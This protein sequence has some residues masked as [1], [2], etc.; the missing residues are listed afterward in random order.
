MANRKLAIAAD[1]TDMAR[2][3]T[4]KSAELQVIIWF[5]E[6]GWELFTPVADLG[7]D[8][9]VRHPKTREL[10]AVQ[11]KHKQ[12]GSLNEGWLQN[13]WRPEEPPFDYLVFF[14]PEKSRVL[15]VPREKLKKPG[16]VF[17]FFAKDRDGY[18][19]GPVRPLFSKYCLELGPVRPED[20]AQRFA[21][22]FAQVH[23]SRNASASHA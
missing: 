9:V 20:R 23:A 22:F 17:I 4:A 7:S 8:I 10:L 5:L 11:I 16:R 21:T 3:N 14:V 13:D 6:A 1:Y 15:V 12:P 18:S 19:R 2:P